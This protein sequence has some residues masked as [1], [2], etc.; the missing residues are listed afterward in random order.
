MENGWVRVVESSK[1]VATTHRVV[2]PREKL[3]S[4]HIRG[5]IF[6]PQSMPLTNRPLKDDGQFL[7]PFS[8]RQL[9]EILGITWNGQV[10]QAI[11][12][13][14]ERLRTIEIRPS[15][16]F[17]L[18]DT[19]E[20]VDNAA[21]ETDAIPRGRQARIRLV[22]E[23]AYDN[24][25]HQPGAAVDPERVDRCTVYFGHHYLRNLKA[26]YLR[27]LDFGLSQALYSPLAKRLYSLLQ[28]IDG[29]GVQYPLPDLA[30]RLPLTARYPS[31]VREKLEPACQ[32][33]QTRG[34]PQAFA[35]DTQ[36]VTFTLTADPKA[37]WAE[38]L[39]DDI[40][41]VTEDPHSRGWYRK[42]TQLLPADILYAVTAETKDAKHRGLIRTSPGAY[43]NDL[44]KRRV[45]QLGLALP[46]GLEPVKAPGPGNQHAEEP[47]IEEERQQI[48]ATRA[49]LTPEE[50]A[51]LYQEAAHAI[52]EDHPHLKLGKDLLIRLKVD[53]L[54]KSAV[55]LT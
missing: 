25:R 50:L 13:A 45:A 30:A 44:L 23:V 28:G 35:F 29:P 39:V 16:A 6:D 7:L 40:L 42:L 51:A 4:S 37:R 22:S 19:G 3:A 15:T 31:K 17:Y 53:E 43:P 11:V 27:T 36:H 18:Q 38:V 21:D 14:L 10:A 52:E 32:E 12:E 34:V 1:R 49:T 24:L 8:F 2:P 46:L 55:S 9:A 33:L 26:R 54:V 48:E 41:A 47:P 20:F 5:L